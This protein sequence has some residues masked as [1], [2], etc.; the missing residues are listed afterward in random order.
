[1]ANR[2]NIGTS[3]FSGTAGG[4]STP[5]GLSWGAHDTY[6]RT[7]YSSRPYARADR[8]YDFYQPA[9]QYGYESATKHSGRKWDE[10]ETDLERG[11][12]KAKGTSQG[13]WADIKHA[14]RDAWD[15]VTGNTDAGAK[16]EIGRDMNKGTAY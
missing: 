5:G 6:W 12:D 7:A 11:W 2:D 13:V 9:Y 15:R 1:M 3:D 8:K 14:V 16:R 10:V 4:T